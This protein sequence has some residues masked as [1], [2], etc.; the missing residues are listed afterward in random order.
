MACMLLSCCQNPN[1]SIRGQKRRSRANP[2]VV[3]HTEEPSKSR[4]HCACLKALPGYSQVA[5]QSDERQSPGV[6]A[7]GKSCRRVERKPALHY[8]PAGA[9]RLIAQDHV[10]QPPDSAETNAVVTH[11]NGRVR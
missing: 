7:L 1:S 4:M 5:V 9:D 3:L 10:H 11:A 6:E 8:S 2:G